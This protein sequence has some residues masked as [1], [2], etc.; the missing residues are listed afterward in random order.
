MAIKTNSI[1]VDRRS[2]DLVNAIYYVFSNSHDVETA[3]EDYLIIFIR[4]D[5]TTII[6]KYHH[7]KEQPFIVSDSD[8]FEDSYI[9]SNDVLNKINDLIGTEDST[10]NLH[11]V[12]N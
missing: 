12:L 6:V 8:S 5:Q 7:S 9:N 4:H 1:Y 2:N 3:F 11:H 10:I